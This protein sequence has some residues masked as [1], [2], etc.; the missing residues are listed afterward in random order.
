MRR[1]RDVKQLEKVYNLQTGKI[2]DKLQLFIDSNLDKAYRPL[3][4]LDTIPK[5]GLD[6][7]IVGC[8]IF[9]ALI[10]FNNTHYDENVKKL[11]RTLTYSKY[12]KIHRHR[13]LYKWLQ[14]VS[15]K[16][17]QPHL[18]IFDSIETSQ[19]R[20]RIAV[21]LI[22]SMPYVDDDLK[23]RL[24]DTMIAVFYYRKKVY[25]DYFYKEILELPFV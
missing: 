5:Y 20:I 4:W 7:N 1:E 3:Y 8:E 11:S 9:E 2:C 25:N 19:V 13:I 16:I 14:W 6:V 12:R 22:N 15:Q 10:D 23:E 24:F 18:M 17:F 21:S